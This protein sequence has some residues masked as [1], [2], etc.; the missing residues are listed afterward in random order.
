MTDKIS[1]QKLKHLVEASHATHVDVHLEAGTEPAEPAADVADV[2]IRSAE[3]ADAADAADKTIR[4][5]VPLLFVNPLVHQAAGLAGEDPEPQQ[6]ESEPPMLRCELCPHLCRLKPGQKGFCRVRFNDGTKIRPTRDGFASSLALDPIE[7]KPLYFF[8]RGA[9]ILSVGF[10]G[11][12]M[13]CPFCQNHDIS[14][15]SDDTGDLTPGSQGKSGD[16]KSGG[17]RKGTQAK[18]AE[19]PGWQVTP[20]GLVTMAEELAGRG[21]IGLCFTYNEPLV[22]YEFVR[23]SFGLAREKGLETVLVTNGCFNEPFIRDIAPL[24]TAWNIDLKSFS[25]EGYNRLAGDLATVKRSIEIANRHSHVEVTTLVVPGL[26]DSPE[27]MEAEARWLASV[28]P[29]IPLHL[30]RFF[31]RYQSEASEPTS[32]ETLHQLATIARRHLK[33]VLLGNV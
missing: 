14:M 32:I 26:S 15:V 8:H 19:V 25:E 29:E 21:N 20:E 9:K 4:P 22:H 31:P 6:E 16:R 7:K 2:A 5:A 27:E 18:A 10:Y 30:T 33:N 1:E 17:Q 24:T 13:R 23:E 3:S 28:N 12:N 11:C